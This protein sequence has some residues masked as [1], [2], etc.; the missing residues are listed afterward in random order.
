M[1]VS[2]W[3][4]RQIR[5]MPQ[6]EQQRPQMWKCRSFWISSSCD[7]SGAMGPPS[8]CRCFL[9]KTDWRKKLSDELS[10]ESTSENCADKDWVSV[11][12]VFIFFW[13]RKLTALLALSL[14]KSVL[15][16][17]LSSFVVE[18]S[19]QDALTTNVTETVPVNFIRVGRR[20]KNRQHQK[21]TWFPRAFLAL[22]CKDPF[23]PLWRFFYYYT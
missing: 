11:F 18:P 6:W 14:D 5:Q 10:N 1:S 4:E 13:L 19:H 17:L 16:S 21:C 9:R 3:M 2:R 15:T 7:C 20:L 22:I 12:S 8:S 23:F